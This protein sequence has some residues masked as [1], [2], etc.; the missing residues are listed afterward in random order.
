MS[1]RKGRP[2]KGRRRQ[3]KLPHSLSRDK[4]VLYQ[5]SV[6][7]ADVDVEFLEKLFQKQFG[8]PARILRE[9]FCGTFLLSCHWVASHPENMAYGLDIDPE[10]LAWGKSHNALALKDNQTNRLFPIRMDVLKGHLVCAVDIVDAQN[11]SWFVFK[12]R[13]TLLAYFSSVYSSLKTEGLFVLDIYGGP[14]AQI[15]CEDV[16]ECDDFD[17]VWE[18]AAYDPITANT[19][20][21]IHFRF[22]DG[23][24][25]P[26]AF[27]YDWRLW[28]IPET[29]D[30]LLEAGFSD[31][32]VA[33]E[34]TGEDGEGDGEFLFT[35][36]P[37]EEDAYVAYMIGVKK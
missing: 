1:R 14:D 32:L 18:Q 8:R 21:H 12:D 33:W 35:N 4:H 34:G 6:N 15:L 3:R 30:V 13:A 27:S 22:P 36:K 7:A 28:T 23:T 37:E 2:R 19:L 5:Q 25:M 9:D 31:V 17:Y 16:R 11:F 10:P 29:R 20:C 24:S 26:Y